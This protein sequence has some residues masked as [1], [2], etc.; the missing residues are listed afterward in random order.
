MYRGWLVTLVTVS[1][2]PSA[3]ATDV[4]RLDGI[5][6]SAEHGNLSLIDG[7][8]R[9]THDDPFVVVEEIH[10]DGPAILTL[11]DV[12]RRFG[13]PG[14]IGFVLRKVVTNAT[15][16]PWTTFEMELREWL[17]L[18]SGY[19]DGLSFAQAKERQS[20][21]GSSTYTDLE[22]YDE[23][24]DRAVFVGGIVMPG[25]SVTLQV[26]ITDHSPKQVFY[27]LQ[28]RDAEVA[29]VEPR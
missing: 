3:E 29:A 24:T 22:I 19:F 12:N 7:W 26:T 20:T 11:R 17:E 14:G 8:G 10:D 2:A 13:I 21:T 1:G 9:G 28:R 27:L 4:L 15:R 16:R 18:E 6:L 5:T 25:E 23:P